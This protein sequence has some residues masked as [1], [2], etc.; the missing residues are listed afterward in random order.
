[1]EISGQAK[2]LW[3][4]FLSNTIGIYRIADL[5]FGILFPVNKQGYLLLRRSRIGVFR[6][7]TLF[8]SPIW[9]RRR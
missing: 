7:P 3:G 4:N 9:S 1:M 5:L 6:N 2:F 8:K